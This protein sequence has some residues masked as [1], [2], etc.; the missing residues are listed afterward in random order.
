ML[1]APCRV[2]SPHDDRLT[3]QL[4]QQYS[5]QVEIA[6]KQVAALIKQ[7]TFRAPRAAVLLL[8]EAQEAGS[9]S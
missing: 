8:L 3:R 7:G 1:G 9:T 6:Q 5:L 4:D 2:I